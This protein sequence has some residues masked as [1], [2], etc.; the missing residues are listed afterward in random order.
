MSKAQIVSPLPGTFYR[1]P[2]PDQPA[3][4]NDGDAVALGDVIGL[5]EVMKNFHEIKADAAGS[6]I[7]FLVEDGD[8]IMPGQAIAELDV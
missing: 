8:A 2:A 3:F 6:N 7:S 4:K 5:A 1:K